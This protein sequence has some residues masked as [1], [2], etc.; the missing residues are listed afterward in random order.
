[1]MNRIQDNGFFDTL[2]RKAFINGGIFIVLFLAFTAALW[3]TSGYTVTTEDGRNASITITRYKY[4]LNMIHNWWIITT[5]AV[6]VVLVLYGLARSI[7]SGHYTSGIWFAGIGTFLVAVSLF[8]T[9]GYGDTSIPALDYRPDK[10][11]DN[12]QCILVA[13]HTDRHELCFDI[14]T[15]RGCLHMVCVASDGQKE[16][17][18]HIFRK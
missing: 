17:T 7:F 8:W 6:G 5:W 9:A 13:V 14:H 18:I 1:M 10:F 11:A 3:L 15:V 12:P 2:K 4:F 16:M